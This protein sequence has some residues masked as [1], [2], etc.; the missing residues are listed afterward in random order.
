[1]IIKSIENGSTNKAIN[2]GNV[3]NTVKNNCIL[4][5]QSK[6]NVL[7]IYSHGRFPSI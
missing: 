1:M 5:T 3:N 4:V 6:K 7:E 2:G